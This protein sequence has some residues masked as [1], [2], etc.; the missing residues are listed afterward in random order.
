MA[1]AGRTRVTL[2]VDPISIH[3]W[4]VLCGLSMLAHDGVIALEVRDLGLVEEAYNLTLR[5]SGPGGEEPRL[6]SLGVGDK[7]GGADVPG[8][9]G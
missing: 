1:D 5:V 2:N 4:S 3:S 9:T 7:G 6:V 8:V